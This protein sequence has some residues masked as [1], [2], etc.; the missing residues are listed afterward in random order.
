MQITRRARKAPSQKAS[1]PGRALRASDNDREQ[2]A[3]RL[4]H[5]AVEGRLLPEELEDRPHAAFSAR[6]PRE[7]RI[8]SAAQPVL[9]GGVAEST[10]A[11]IR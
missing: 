11:L 1:P 8:R 6:D 9:A 3:A 7:T 5:A 2:T 4:R 10:P